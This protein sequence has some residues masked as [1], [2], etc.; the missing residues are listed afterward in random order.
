MVNIWLRAGESELMR[1]ALTHVHHH[2]STECS[3]VNGALDEIATHLG[4]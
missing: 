4:S 2:V 3:N 1:V